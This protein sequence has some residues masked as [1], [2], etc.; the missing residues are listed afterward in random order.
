MMSPCGHAFLA[1]HKK[2]PSLDEKGPLRNS[3]ATIRTCMFPFS[4]GGRRCFRRHP[5]GA[6]R[7]DFSPVGD[8]T[9]RVQIVGWNCIEGDSALQEE[10]FR[11][12][13]KMF[14]VVQFAC[15]PAFVI[16]LELSD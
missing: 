15:A 7:E 2:T 9:R 4:K 5:Q 10:I 16:L 8:A 6:G 3:L 1:A 11:E 12:K 14:L 13:A